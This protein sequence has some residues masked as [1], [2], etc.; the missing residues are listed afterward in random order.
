MACGEVWS[1]EARS[2]NHSGPGRSSIR[3]NERVFRCG[4]R[5]EHY[6]S[7]CARKIKQVVP[8]LPQRRARIRP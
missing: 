3:S 2:T 4:F 1:S 7:A 5:G 8:S 6:A